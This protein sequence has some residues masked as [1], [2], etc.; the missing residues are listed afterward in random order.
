MACLQIKLNDKTAELALTR[1]I[2][3]GRNP[4]NDLALPVKEASRVHFML[5]RL[6]EGGWAIRDLGSTNG[7]LV[8]GGKIEK[9]T[10]LWHKDV[11]QLGPNCTITFW[12]PQRQAAPEPEPPKPKRPSGPIVVKSRAQKLKEKQEEE[13]RQRI[14]AR[15]KKREASR[16]PEPADM[17][18]EKTA[19]IEAPVE[20]DDRIIEIESEATLDSLIK[21]PA[22]ADKL[23]KG[24]REVRFGPYTIKARMAEGGMGYVVKAYHRK[25]KA[26]VAL[27]LLRTEKVDENN[28]A[29][30][31]QEAWA[32]S[33]FDHPN[34]V[35]VRDLGRHAGMHYIAMDYIDGA[36]LLKVGFEG[37]L[38]FWQVME[39]IDKMAG[40]LKLV[41]ARN[42]LHRDLKPQNILLDRKGEVRLIDFGIATVERDHDK[43]TETA[44]GLIMGTPAFLSPEQAARGKLGEVDGRA[45]LYSLGAVMY[46]LLTGRRPFTGRSAI[47][48]LKNNM[49][50]PPAHPHTVDK[51]IP[52]GLVH[53]CLK[54]LEKHPR[55]RFQDAG[56]L[57]QEL[58]IWRKSPDGKAELERHR[59]IIRMRAAKAKKRG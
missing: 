45:D 20:A 9:I 10:R 52:R 1:N 48:I 40:V 43:A 39:T 23:L 42:I 28:I 15:K 7:T 54:L 44:E 53:I 16:A 50:K 24:S 58:A 32:I 13:L 11:I 47:E 25:L 34:I 46:Y 59:K 6:K 31:K 37:T 38:T 33:A 4:D 26:I 35:K 19:E 18:A 27:K 51:M 5:G 3:A 57:Q 49:T 17:E 22:A 21:D 12:D 36:D 55:A 41:H 30:F 8:N 56:S 14:E 29:R 2:K